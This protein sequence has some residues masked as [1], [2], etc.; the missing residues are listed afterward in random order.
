MVSLR[1]KIV[2]VALM[3]LAVL[4]LRAGDVSAIGLSILPLEVSIDGS[5]GK[6]TVATLKITNTSSDSALFE[7]YPDDLR[8]MIAISPAS[9][10]LQGGGS[11]DISITMN[12][13]AGR[14]ETMISVISNPLSSDGLKT[15]VG[16]KIPLR[17]SFADGETG[18]LANISEALGVGALPVGL[19]IGALALFLR[20]FKI[21]PR[22]REEDDC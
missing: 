3:S 13:S 1:M 20:F 10:T 2:V 14:F 4:F 22:K 7:V 16:I 12:A 18:F 9:F 11:R 15:G 5:A 19:G 21:S 17:A 8:S 6:P